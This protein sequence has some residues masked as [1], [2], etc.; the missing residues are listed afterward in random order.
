MPVAV[1]TCLSDSG[2]NGSDVISTL[3]W[4]WFVIIHL[5]INMTGYCEHK[6]IISLVVIVYPIWLH[7]VGM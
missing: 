4:K 6:P 3:L 7:P 2:C 5:Q 1:G